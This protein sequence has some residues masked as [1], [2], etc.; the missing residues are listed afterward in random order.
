MTQ[1]IS[2]HEFKTL[3]QKSTDTPGIVIRK[4]SQGHSEDAGNR[5]IRFVLSSE[6]VDR[7]GDKISQAGWELKNYL[8]NPVVLW[9]HDASSLPIGKCVDISVVN[10]K[11][12]GT[13]EFVPADVP[14]IGAK[15]E[16]VY[17]LVKQGFLSATS[18]GFAAYEYDVS[19]D[20]TR[21]SK[22]MPG[23]DFTRMELREFSIV[24]IPANPD[25]LV[26]APISNDQPKC[27]DII[28]HTKA[29]SALAYRQ[30]KLILA[31]LR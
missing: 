11:L 3:V 28:D 19:D 15:A 30:R 27:A 4:D 2:I 20:D 13:V 12:V 23:L 16:A 31:T 1:S 10:G 24:T 22:Y 17:Q 25:A 26:Q 8:N 29:K 7:D 5:Q 9:Q 18:V 6:S 14:V 21:G